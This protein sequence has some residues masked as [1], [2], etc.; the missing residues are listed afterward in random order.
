[1]AS[2]EWREREKL[3]NRG[4]VFGLPKPEMNADK[5]GREKEEKS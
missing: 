2:G 1:V 3:W 5:H 4:P